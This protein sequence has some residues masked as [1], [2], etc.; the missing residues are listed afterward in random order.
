MFVFELCGVV[1]GVT[2][3]FSIQKSKKQEQI[4]RRQEEIKKEMDERKK[5]DEQRRNEKR[6]SVSR[7]SHRESQSPPPL[8]QRSSSPPIPTMR[9]RGEEADQA[10]EVGGTRPPSPGVV[11]SLHSL[12]Q[13][14]QRRRESLQYQE[15]EERLGGEWTGLAEL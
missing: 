10:G 13:N 5:Q 7:H 15:E 12:R 8:L 1:S 9:G 14:I 3:T 2:E 11:E 4:A 6:R